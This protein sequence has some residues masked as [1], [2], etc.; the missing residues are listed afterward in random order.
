[1]LTR[2]TILLICAIALSI[3]SM[4][5]QVGGASLSTYCWTWT[6]GDTIASI[7]VP[8]GFHRSS[9][10]EY[11]EGKTT[12]LIWGDSS[13]VLLQFGGNVRTPL[14]RAPDFVVQDSSF[15]RGR[16]TRWGTVA[17]TYYFWREDGFGPFHIAYFGVRHDRV[18]LFDSSFR[19]FAPHDATKSKPGKV[20]DSKSDR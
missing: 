16:L 9:E 5:C 20:Q 15:S 12:T 1:M 8:R 7:Q 14:L 10:E 17:D 19:T 13:V 3:Q 6:L 11:G 4:K 18:N 2:C